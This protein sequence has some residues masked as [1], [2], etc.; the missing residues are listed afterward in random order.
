MKDITIN[1]MGQRKFAAILSIVLLVVSIGSL[2]IKRLNLGLDFTGGTLIELGYQQPASLDQIRG[3]LNEQGF[4]NAVVVFYGSETDVLIRFQGSLEDVGLAQLDSVLPSLGASIQSLEPSSEQGWAN[5]VVLLNAE[6]NSA[7]KNTLFPEAI[8]GPS[9]INDLRGPEVEIFLE[10]NFAESISQQLVAGLSQAAG[11]GNDVIVKR[12]D[13]VFGAVGEELFVNAMLGLLLALGLIM[14]YIVFRFQFKFAVGAVAA[15]AHDVIIVLGF[16]S[17]VN[18]EFDLTVLAAVLAIIGYSLND[19]I[20]V[21][22]RIREN[23]R[24]Q[25]KGTAVEVVNNSLNQVIGRTLVTSATTL[26][27]LLA[28]F[29]YGGEVIHGF[30]EA[31]IVGILVGTYSSIYVAANILLGMKITKEDLAVPVKEGADLDGGMV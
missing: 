22:D 27:V 12:R 9:I 31:L 25:R 4:E 11:A 17:L 19:T 3:V 14:I 6:A 7:T 26:L 29:F 23:F 1:F 20:V 24:K 28:L 16:F 10:K 8:F 15:L 13:Y 5:R 2:A 30:A 21:S 18:V